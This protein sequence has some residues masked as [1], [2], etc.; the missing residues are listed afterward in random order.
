MTLDPALGLVVR[1]LLCLLL[2]WACVH[3]LRD[4]GAFATTI[5]QYDVLPRGWAIVSAPAFAVC[6]FFLVVGLFVPS[7]YRGAGIAVAGLM[8]LYSLAIGVNLLRGRRDIDCG[9][10]GPGYRQPLSGG[11][12]VR[13]TVVIAAGLALMLPESGRRLS[14][15]D[16]FSVAAAGATFALLFVAANQLLSQEP[17]LRMLRR[18]P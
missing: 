18:I 9:C 3:K 14:W 13:N 16:A 15:I 2:L 4:L 10:L 5:E 12:L 17:R 11:L 7:A 1:G 8:S 6:E